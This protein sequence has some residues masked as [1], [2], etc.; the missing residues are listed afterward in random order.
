MRSITWSQIHSTKLKFCPNDDVVNHLNSIKLI[1]IQHTNID[2]LWF[3]VYFR[4]PNAA[5]YQLVISN[6]KQSTSIPDRTTNSQTSDVLSQMET[7]HWP[8]SND[9]EIKRWLRYFMGIG[10][11]WSSNSNDSEWNLS[12]SATIENCTNV[13][14]FTITTIVIITAIWTTT[15][16]WSKQFAEVFVFRAIHFHWLG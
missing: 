11:S 5:I 4:C 1:K 7:V 6:G 12:S 9:A 16:H 8:W 13:L 10:K 15:T 14:S 3:S 2:S